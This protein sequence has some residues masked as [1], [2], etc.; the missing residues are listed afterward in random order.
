[1]G[2]GGGA[3]RDSREGSPLL[4]GD[5]VPSL[6]GLHMDGLYGPVNGEEDLCPGLMGVT[7][8]LAVQPCTHTYTHA[9]TTYTPMLAHTHH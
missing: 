5:L 3:H 6:G 1:M 8:A 7:K 2:G 4:G 9:M